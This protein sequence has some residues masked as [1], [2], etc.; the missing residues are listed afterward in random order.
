MGILRFVLSQSREI[1]IKALIINA[2]QHFRTKLYQLCS[3]DTGGE[4]I[5]LV[6]NP[7]YPNTLLS[8]GDEIQ[9]QLIR[10]AYNSVKKIQLRPKSLVF[11]MWIFLNFA[12]YLFKKLIQSIRCFVYPFINLVFKQP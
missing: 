1:G 7:N 8:N 11:E 5:L 9:I 3:M 10:S 6:V 4:K 2:Y 12:N